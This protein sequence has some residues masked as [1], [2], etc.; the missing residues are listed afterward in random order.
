ME[1]FALGRIV[2]EQ[3]SLSAI[4]AVQAVPLQVEDGDVE[5]VP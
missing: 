1:T 3:Q 4:T 2:N 5:T